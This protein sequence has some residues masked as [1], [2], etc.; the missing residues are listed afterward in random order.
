MSSWMRGIGFRQ[1]KSLH[2]SSLHHI[3]L[4]NSTKSSWLTTD[5]SFWLQ[6]YPNMTLISITKEDMVGWICSLPF[7]ISRKP[8]QA[9]P[10]LK[11]Q[12]WPWGLPMLPWGRGGAMRKKEKSH[13]LSLT[14]R[15]LCFAEI[16][17]YSKSHSSCSEISWFR[18]IHVITS[19]SFNSLHS[20][21]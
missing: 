19:H 13:F 12:L 8:N 20:P 15:D 21:R 2:F 7:L 9:I 18:G 10:T 11:L 1:Y 3:S 17:K 14:G 5:K 16:R 6:T 4:T